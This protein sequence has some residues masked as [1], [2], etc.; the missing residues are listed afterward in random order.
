MFY[1]VTP[2]Q[3]SYLLCVAQVKFSVQVLSVFCFEQLNPLPP[4]LSGAA[5]DLISG[6]LWQQVVSGMCVDYSGEP[7]SSLHRCRP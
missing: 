2:I 3:S 5:E 4:D 6:V 7:L 1:T